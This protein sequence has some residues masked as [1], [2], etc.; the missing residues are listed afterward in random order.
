VRA[1]RSLHAELVRNRLSQADA[2]PMSRWQALNNGR[3][4][5]VA[6]HGPAE[7]SSI[8]LICSVSGFVPSCS[9]LVGMGG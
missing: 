5:T 7:P 1:R 3:S 9:G 8:V 4:V 2:F 6:S